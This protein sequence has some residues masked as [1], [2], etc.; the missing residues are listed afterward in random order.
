MLF[1]S[2]TVWKLWLILKYFMNSRVSFLWILCI[3]FSIVSKC[4]QTTDLM[5][6]AVTKKYILH[7]LF[8]I[9]KV[10]LHEFWCG[11]LLR[12]LALRTTPITA[13]T[14]SL[15]Q[16]IKVNRMKNWTLVLLCNLRPGNLSKYDVCCLEHLLCECTY[17]S[18]HPTLLPFSLELKKGDWHPSITPFQV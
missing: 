5:V 17:C 9:Y 13:I 7:F 2:F 12:K 16:L 14:V 6:A 11:W 8:K 3:L 4:D 1:S 18:L 15:V 10:K